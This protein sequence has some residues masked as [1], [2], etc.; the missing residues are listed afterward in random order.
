MCT[1]L[2]LPQV[3]DF[4]LAKILE[5][6]LTHW[7]LKEKERVGEIVHKADVSNTREPVLLT[8]GGDSEELDSDVIQNVAM[9]MADHAKHS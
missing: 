9:K 2:L 8:L 3:S 5:S 7:L 1:E 4:Q 6:L